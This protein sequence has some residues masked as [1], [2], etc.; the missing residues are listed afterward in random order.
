MR[1]NAEWFI[2]VIGITIVFFYKNSLF[3]LSWTV[4]EKPHTIGHAYKRRMVHYEYRARLCKNFLSSFGFD[5]SCPTVY[6]I[7]IRSW[8]DKKRPVTALCRTP[9]IG[10]VTA[11]RT[12]WAAVKQTT[13]QEAEVQPRPVIVEPLPSPRLLVEVALSIAHWGDH[14]STVRQDPLWI[15]HL[16][17]VQRD[18]RSIVQIDPSI[19]Q[20]EPGQ[21]SI[22]Q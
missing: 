12:P 10:P 8:T 14:R 7:S 17:T 19:F 6:R 18:L 2:I 22:A 1:T 11:R 9:W 5:F 13:E 20:S 16:L 3:Y 4:K 15:V 21:L